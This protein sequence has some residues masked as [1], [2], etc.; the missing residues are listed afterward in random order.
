MNKN[1]DMPKSPDPDPDPDTR[2]QVTGDESDKVV[3]YFGKLL[4]IWNG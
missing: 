4:C 1:I 3:Y 2:L